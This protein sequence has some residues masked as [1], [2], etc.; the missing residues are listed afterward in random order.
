MKI[1][2][3]DAHIKHIV[4]TASAMMSAARTAPKAH[5][6]DRL[7]CVAL[8]GEE[9]NALTAEMRR[10]AAA[11]CQ[12]FIARDAE[13]IDRSTCVVLLGTRNEP[14]GMDCG[15][16]GKETC[17]QAMMEGVLCFFAS[18]DLGLAV[19]SAVSIAADM[20]VDSR[21]MFSAGIAAKDLNVFKSP[22]QAAVG[23]PISVSE[24][25]IYFDRG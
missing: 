16:C 20:R 6:Y 4:N 19:G 12:D 14:Y 10:I 24:K 21:V 8:T 15:Y 1:E 22:V 3:K 23:I 2:P 5:G 17:R 11:T 18:H 7:E 25:S 9:K 13:N